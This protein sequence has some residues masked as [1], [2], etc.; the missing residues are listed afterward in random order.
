MRTRKNKYE[1][2]ETFK[3]VRNLYLDDKANGTLK[4]INHY[5]KQMKL[6]VPVRFVEQYFNGEI[7]TAKFRDACNDYNGLFDQ[8]S[9]DALL[10][11]K[12]LIGKYGDNWCKR[13]GGEFCISDDGRILLKIE[14]AN[15]QGT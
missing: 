3:A 6:R 9:D 13:F 10:T 15:E 5:K 14:N 7:S 4:T 2:I 12:S 11:V 1:R 8:H